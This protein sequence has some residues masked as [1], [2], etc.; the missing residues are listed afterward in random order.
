MKASLSLV[1]FFGSRSAEGLKMNGD[2]CKCIPWPYVYNKLFMGGVSC[3]GG[4]AGLRADEACPFFRNFYKNMCVREDRMSQDEKNYCIV[5]KACSGA[6]PING[7]MWAKKT[8]SA[9]QGDKSI[10]DLPFKKMRSFAIDQEIDMSTLVGLSAHLLRKHVNQTTRKEIEAI[11][12]TG[13]ATL[14]HE[15]D[16]VFG[17]KLQVKGSQV[18]EHKYNEMVQGFWE[19]TCVE[20][21]KTEQ[22]RIAE[23][24]CACMNWGDIFSKNGEEGGMDCTTYMPSMLAADEFC[25]MAKKLKSNVCL[26]EFRTTNEPLSHPHCLVRA[27]C[28]TAKLVSGQEHW[29]ERACK[30]DD[31]WISNLN[32]TEILDIATSSEVDAAILLG[33]TTTHI[34]KHADDITPGE[35]RSILDSATPTFVWKEKDFYADRLLIKDGVVSSMTFN[36]ENPM[37]WDATCMQGCDKKPA[38]K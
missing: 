26:H 29:R 2:D 17:R 3:E 9:A 33:Y 27:S 15:P 18:W 13:I 16:D 31:V 36:P 12:A 32:S 11:K 38:S 30:K 24:D 8:C 23:D 4:I 20:G 28:A 6:E 21:C 5:T 7:S 14:I 34:N 19:M 35:L 10:S 22:L 25:E 37:S 1:L